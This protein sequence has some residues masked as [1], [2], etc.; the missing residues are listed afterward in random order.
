MFGRRFADL[1]LFCVTATELV[2]LF[3]LTPTFRIADWIYVVQ[4]SLVLGIA[5]SR[6]PPKV[7]DDSIPASIAVGVAY[8]YAYAQ[9]IY[10][11]WSPGDVAWPSGGLALVTAGAGLSL[12]SLITMRGRFGVRP[13]LRDLVTVG[14]YRFVRHPM[15]LSY[16]LA[17]IGYNLEEWNFVTVLLVLLGWG[18][19]IYR[20]HAEER[21]LSA[22]SEWPS[23]TASVRY[24]LF[25][26]LW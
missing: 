26:G 7:R 12:L 14:P 5:L 21:V 6:P 23:Y 1:L 8:T 24:R 16:I 3:L 13:A 4:H 25:P 10:L 22:H 15:Y 11:R 9:V 2:I 18:S 19:L 17:D 20:I